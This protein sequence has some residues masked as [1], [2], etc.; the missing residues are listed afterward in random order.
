MLM[1]FQY[2]ILFMTL[3]CSELLIIM[4]LMKEIF[5]SNWFAEIYPNNASY[6]RG[7]NCC[8]KHTNHSRLQPTLGSLFTVFQSP[9]HGACGWIGRL[10][11]ISTRL[12]GARELCRNRVT[13]AIVGHW[14]V[15][16][17]EANETTKRTSHI[18]AVSC[19][20]LCLNYLDLFNYINR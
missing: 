19:V 14:S 2:F 15:T 9:W 8:S 13:Y 5:M 16:V 11:V 17:F 7:F 4:R 12:S 10:G 18:R 1:S 6:S 3:L 20:D